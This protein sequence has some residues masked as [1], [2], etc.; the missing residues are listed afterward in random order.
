[1][2][3]HS[4]EGKLQ[5]GGPHR[6]SVVT[7][8][9]FELQL[10]TGELS[11]HGQR[12]RL[13][14]A[15]FH[16]LC[17]LLERPGR[18]VTR[19]ELRFK[20]WPSNTFV[21]F[22][23]GLNTAMNR[24]RASLGDSAE[25]P[26]YVETLAR[27][28]YRFIAPVRTSSVPLEEAILSK[29]VTVS[30][31]TDE[32]KA[33]GSRQRKLLWMFAS[34]AAG[35][36][37]VALLISTLSPAPVVFRQLTF[38]RGIVYNAR[39]LSGGNQVIYDAALNGKST[40]VFVT[41]AANTPPGQARDLGYEKVML[42]SVS[43]FGDV[44]VFTHRD[45]KGEGVLEQVPV[46][47]GNPRLL[48]S[49][50]RDMDWSP[51]G[52]LCLLTYDN[53]RYAIEFP[54]GHSVYSSPFWINYPRVSSRGDKVAFLE[55][56][57]PG[58]DAGRVVMVDSAGKSRTLSDGWESIDGLAWQPRGR[59]VWFT[60]ARSGVDRALMAVNED[61]RTRQV[62]QIP[63]GMLL[64]DIS[65]SGDALISRATSHMTMLY[66]DLNTKSSRDIS[67]L[68]WSTPSA[69]S[70]D[71][72]RVLFD[73][74]GQGGGSRYTVYLFRV[75]TGIAERVSEGRPLDLSG[76][77]KWALTQDA[78]DM[79][80]VSLVSIADRKVTRV[81]TSG[82]EYRWARFLPPDDCKEIL[83]AGNYAGKRPQLYRQYLPDGAPA[84]V[85]PSVDLNDGV[86][87]DIGRFAAGLSGSAVILIV[88][89]RTGIARSV[90]NAKHLEPIAFAGNNRLITS[91]RDDN[92][93][94]LEYLNTTTGELLPYQRIGPFDATGVADILPV[95][96]AK[97]LNTF[98]YSRL[99]TLSTL[100]I[101]SGW[102]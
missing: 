66:G 18:V 99:Q 14:R 27:L 3:E 34:F 39:F 9:P 88:D 22:E 10:D 94:D 53:G 16:I 89:L 93:I 102:R 76:D 2:D 12:V 31:Q 75:D 1:M 35:A 19:E 70:S 5:T 101:V 26:I 54:P 21:D 28:G 96:L 49:R 92:F 51:N 80:K 13:Q 85:S 68:D 4:T 91:R 65:P 67:W 55:H 78:A 23:S 11:K 44:A 98:V 97:D 71:N 90:P 87:D 48:P 30:S 52:K 77:G 15:P 17:A 20:V 41:K 79:S 37:A 24:L 45:G 60:A 81:S 86:V 83:F 72:K 32:A 64:R 8:G 56:P 69:I 36:A 84:L 38:S 50:A 95:R 40:H 57:V 100:Y 73:E 62:A 82:L 33:A 42:A 25:N 59:E 6:G 47:G 43:P 58:D 61:G 63:G 74:S 7:F 46:K 29:L